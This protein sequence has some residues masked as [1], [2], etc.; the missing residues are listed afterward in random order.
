MLFPNSLRNKSSNCTNPKGGPTLWLCLHLM[1]SSNTLEEGCLMKAHEH[2][3]SSG[4]LYLWWHHVYHHIL[5]PENYV[6][7]SVFRKLKEHSSNIIICTNK[8]TKA[9]LNCLSHLDSGQG[10]TPAHCP[11]SKLKLF[12]IHSPRLIKW[13][14]YEILQS[15]LFQEKRHG[16]P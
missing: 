5:E 4:L 3:L 2:P 14:G 9:Q 15:R 11:I 16:K 1:F 6:K 12:R 7:I 8:A 13:P 10:R